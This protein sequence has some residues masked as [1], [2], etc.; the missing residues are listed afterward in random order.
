MPQSQVIICKYICAY[1]LT[2]IRICINTNVSTCIHVFLQ[3][4]IITYVYQMWKCSN[5]YLRLVGESC[6]VATCNIATAESKSTATTS[7]IVLPL[8]I[9]IYSTF[10]IYK[11]KISAKNNRSMRLKAVNN[12]WN[13]NEEAEKE[14]IPQILFT[15]IILIRSS[16]G[17]LYFFA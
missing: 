4:N 16:F 6:T 3:T 11:K 17:F 2:Y 7:F 13:T 14:L 1:I 9:F 12:A 8:K 5:I 10:K 15:L